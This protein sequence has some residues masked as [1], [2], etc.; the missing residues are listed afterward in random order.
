MLK[1]VG[2]F[3]FFKLLFN[4]LVLGLR[5]CSYREPIRLCPLGYWCGRERLCIPLTREFLGSLKY[6]QNHLADVVTDTNDDV[7]V[8]FEDAARVF[9]KLHRMKRFD[10]NNFYGY[11]DDSYNTEDTYNIQEDYNKEDYKEDYN[12]EDYNKED[13]NKEDYDTGD[14]Y[15]LEDDVNQKKSYP[16]G[17]DRNNI[18]DT[19]KQWLQLAHQGKH[20]ATAH[21]FQLDMYRVKVGEHQKTEAPKRVSKARNEDRL[22]KEGMAKLKDYK[23]LEKKLLHLNEMKKMLVGKLEIIKQ[24]ES[25]IKNSL[26][27][28]AQ[29]ERERK[30]SPGR[31]R[32]YFEPLEDVGS[33]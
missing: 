16:S 7:M 24:Q 29:A 13:Y 27:N 28:D 2:Y 23:S 32:F 31:G 14:Y 5:K 9:S 15:G 18:H 25:K 10:P 19:F 20:S 8:D 4:I 6:A 21:P 26:D 22:I 11:A 12:K 1:K 30:V 17:D 33:I 3:Y